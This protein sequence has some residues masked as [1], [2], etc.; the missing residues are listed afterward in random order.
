MPPQ[1]LLKKR[2]ISK[3]T[4][5][6]LFVTNIHLLRPPRF[7][8]FPLL[9]LPRED[10]VLVV[11]GAEDS[12]VFE[13]SSPS[14]P[15]LPASVPS[16]SSSLPS[17]CVSSSLAM[18]SLSLPRPFV[19]STSTCSRDERVLPLVWRVLRPRL[20]VREGAGEERGSIRV[21]T[22]SVMFVE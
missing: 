4:V 9:P 16:A 22:K 6:S 13:S 11:R 12:A 2:Y 15:S 18:L 21:G 5:S 10:C 19:D 3:A 20:L 17:S 1:K 8:L 7:V 14:L